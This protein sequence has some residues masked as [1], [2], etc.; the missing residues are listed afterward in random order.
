MKILFLTPEDDRP[1]PK[2]WSGT[3][4][5]ILRGLEKLGHSVLIQ[6]IETNSLRLYGG[7]KR[8]LYKRLLKQHFIYDFDPLLCWV[9][10]RKLN[11]Q[12]RGVS[13]DLVFSWLPWLLLL[14]DTDKPKV[15]WYDTTFIKTQPLY[16]AN[17]CRE[18]IRDGIQ[19]DGQIAREADAGIYPSQ[20]AVDSAV[21]D[22][23][24]DAKKIH[25]VSFGANFPV[26][27]AEAV[28]G[29]MEQRLS[30]RDEP[31]RLLFV[32]IDWHRKGGD[33]AVAV[34]REINRR[35]TPARL[36]IVGCHPDLAPNDLA[37][38]D[39][40]GRLDKNVPDQLQRMQSLYLE[41]DFFLMPSRGESAA[42][43]Y[44]EAM[45]SGCPS[46]AAKTGGIAT[47]VRDDITGR[48]VDWGDNT[49]AELADYAIRLHADPT[50]YR[51]LC[52]SCYRT[53]LAEFQWEVGWEKLGRILDQTAKSATPAFR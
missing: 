6:R 47:I 26:P 14:V 2:V 5:S 22:Y 21:E 52:E 31:M 40:L 18:S 39:I 19:R 10:R 42:I 25:L 49:V 46:L 32:G 27:P 9:A 13:Y 34:A 28:A 29:A 30:R 33:V 16:F 37:F 17:L 11:R 15:F 12:I 1:L 48:L 36:T 4:Y 23:R 35:G 41:S 51:A 43:V 7:A 24:A 3:A 53:F 20:W 8:R 50:A 38:C 44:C 45:C